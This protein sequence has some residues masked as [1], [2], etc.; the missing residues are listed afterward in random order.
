VKTDYPDWKRSAP[1]ARLRA[2]RIGGADE[3][4]AS[5]IDLAA[6]ITSCPVEEMIRQKRKL[7]MVDARAAAY[8]AL[9]V[10][11]D[12]AVSYPRLG[13][14]F[15]RH[16]TTIMHAVQN[17]TPQ[18]EELAEQIIEAYEAEINGPPQLFAVGE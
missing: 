17:A 3:F 11:S 7:W 16:H 6:L 13:V 4:I 1:S 15:D 18:A 12:G 8:I 9:R 5:V 2:G 10:L 14:E